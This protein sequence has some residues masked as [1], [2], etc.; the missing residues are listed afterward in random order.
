M[1]KQVHKTGTTGWKSTDAVNA[2]DSV[3]YLI[4]Y[5]NTSSVTQ[6]NVVVK[7]VLPAGLTYTKGTT[8]VTNGTNPNGLKVGDNV[9][10]GSGINIGNYSAAAAGYVK[11]SATVPASQDSLVCGVNNFH[12]VAAVETDEGTKTGSADVTVTKECQPEKPVYTC[13]SLSATLVSGTEYKFTGKATAKNGATIKDYKFDFG[14]SSNAIVTNPTDV[15]HTYADNGNSYTARLNVTVKVD[16]SE[17]TVTSDACT[18]KITVGEQPPVIPPELPTTGAGE[19]IAAFLGLG[20]I[21]T[22]F[23]YYLSSRRHALKK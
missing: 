11:F 6:N 9:V 3:D 23:G 17:E 16:N 22:S 1:S 15:A 2:G 18:V 8:Y 4:S 21:V 12:N 13:D 10:T 5:K 14:D 7:D 20:A 19:N